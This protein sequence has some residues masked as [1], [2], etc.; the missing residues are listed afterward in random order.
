MNLDMLAFSSLA[1]S[2]MRIRTKQR[3]EDTYRDRMVAHDPDGK[4][5]LE[6]VKGLEKSAGLLSRPSKDGDDLIKDLGKLGVLK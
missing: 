3:I 1:D 5:V 6:Y 2:A 4:K